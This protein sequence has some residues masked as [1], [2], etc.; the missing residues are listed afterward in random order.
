M[1]KLLLFA[2]DPGGANV[3]LPVYE[4]IKEQY[5]VLAYAREFAW[6]RLADAGLPARNIDKECATLTYAD[7]KNFL[8]RQKPDLV[9]TSTSLDDFTERYLWKASEELHIKS[10]AILD[11]WMNL[12]IRFSD[13]DY[14]QEERYRRDRR[15]PYLPYRILAMDELAGE[16]LKEDGIHAEKIAL[17]GQPHFDTVRER[18]QHAAQVYGSD[19]WN[20]VFASEPIYRNYDCCDGTKRY[21]G[22]NERTIFDNLYD[23]LQKA[24]ADAPGQIRLII[25]PH[26]REDREYWD[27]LAD[28]LNNAGI[29]LAVDSENDS[30]SVLK[31]A[32]L[33]CGMSSMFLLEA[34]ICGKQVVSVAIGLKRENPFVLDKTGQCKSVLTEE[35]LLDKLKQAF[36]QK[37]LFLPENTWGGVYG[38]GYPKGVVNA[39]DKVIQLIEEE[40]TE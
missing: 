6:K 39:T 35:E 17:T 26:P 10:F 16:L 38:F 30:F 18:F 31:S 32:D 7:I 5:E 34:M 40:M 29:T 20:V 13:C 33:V 37:S 23:C 24:A 8:K 2:R 12:G 27:A 14:S 36:L 15:H 25:R 22:Y 21:W 4:K 9:I 3:I 1:K 11:Q 19:K 28:K